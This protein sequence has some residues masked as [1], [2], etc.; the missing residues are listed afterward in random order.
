[1]VFFYKYEVRVTPGTHPALALY[2]TLGGCLGKT[3]HP[4]T[5]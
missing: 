1:M 4:L 3:R 2:A 5:L